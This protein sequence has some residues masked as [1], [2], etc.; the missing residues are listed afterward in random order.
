M[1][2]P[3]TDSKVEA[4]IEGTCQFL[5]GCMKSGSW[6]ADRDGFASV[7]RETIKAIQ[8]SNSPDWAKNH[9]VWALLE[10]TKKRSG[11]LGAP[12]RH[13]RDAAIGMAAMRLVGLTASV[14]GR[15]RDF[16]DTHS[17]PA[18]RLLLLASLN[19]D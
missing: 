9:A 8:R 6:K 2:D 14:I 1:R 17:N 15:D 13:Y 3:T 19:A 11:K 7:M 5:E 16:F 12:T 4:A 18:W 10:Q